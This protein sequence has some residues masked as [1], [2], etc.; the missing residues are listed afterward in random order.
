MKLT[1]LSAAWLP[2]WTCRLMPAP[3]NVGRGHRF[4]AYPRC[5]TDY[6]V[7]ATR[8]GDREADGEGER[9]WTLAVLR[10]ELTD[11]RLLAVALDAREELGAELTDH[12]RLVER[13]PVVHLPTLEVAGLAARLKQRANVSC[14]LHQTSR[15]ARYGERGWGRDRFRASVRL[16]GLRQFRLGLW[17]RAASEKRAG[18]C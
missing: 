17:V 12:F 4:A 13:V 11:D 9:E 6:D 15:I 10:E 5:S 18:D 2:E 8:L 14:E 16:V 1:K 7:S 3:V